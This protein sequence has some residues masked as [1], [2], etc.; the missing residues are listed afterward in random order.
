MRAIYGAL[1]GRS[2]YELVTAITYRELFAIPAHERFQIAVL[3]HTLSREDLA[4]VAQLIR[5]RWSSARILVVCADVPRI[6]D[7]LYDDRV[8]PGL[9]PEMLFTVIDRLAGGA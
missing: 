7:P 1:F 4:S 5:C 6:D 3:N 9:T 2:G 8:V